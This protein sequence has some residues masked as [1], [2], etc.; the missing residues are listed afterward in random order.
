MPMCAL[1]SIMGCFGVFTLMYLQQRRSKEDLYFALLANKQYNI[2][3]K[4]TVVI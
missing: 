4:N 2:N 1:H 3:E